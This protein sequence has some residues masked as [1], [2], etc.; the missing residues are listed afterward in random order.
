M[1]NGL[2]LTGPGMS[3]QEFGGELIWDCH[4]IPKWN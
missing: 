4:Y 3:V 2:V 1:L